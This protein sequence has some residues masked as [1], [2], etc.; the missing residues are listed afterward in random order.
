MARLPEYSYLV[1]REVRPFHFMIFAKRSIHGVLAGWLFLGAAV[2]T[3]AQG[4]DVA[5]VFPGAPPAADGS[6][7]VNLTPSGLPHG[8]R[9]VGESQWHASGEVVGGLTTS[10]RD[11]EFRPVRGYNAPPQEKVHIVSGVA[12]TL[13]TFDYYDASATDY[14]SLTLTLKPDGIATA[15]GPNRAQWR[16]LGEDDSS[17]RDSNKTEEDLV[18]GSYLVECKPVAGR[19]TP[20]TATVIIDPS[21]NRPLTL[22]YF[23]ADAPIGTPPAVL[24]YESVTSDTTKPYAYV[25]QIR[26]DTT[27]GS[28]FV[29][30]Q[31]VVA[32]AAHV[33]WDDA[34]LSSVQGLQWLFQRHRGVHEPESMIPRGFYMFANYSGERG[35]EDTPGT[36]SPA[37]QDLDVAALYFAE[38]PGRGGHSGYVVSNLAQNEFL[39]SHASK[40]LVGYPMDGIA[41]IFQG[42][43]HATP[44]LDLGFDAVLGKTFTTTGIH[45]MAGISGG[46]LCVQ[47]ED[48]NYYPAAICLAGGGQT[49]VRAID[50]EVEELFN[51]AN[52]GIVG[53]GATHIAV[54]PIEAGGKGAIRII[55]EPAAARDASA[56]WRLS[57]SLIARVSGHQISN[58][59]PGGYIASLAPLEGYQIPTTQNI[60]IAANTLT[61]VTYTY[62]TP[63]TPLESW[64]QLHFGTNATNS[65]DAAD[66][67]DPDHDGFNNLAEYT[68]DT[69]PTSTMDYLRSQNPTRGAGTFSLSTA[70]KAGRSYE[71][72]RSATLPAASWTSVA[73]QGP[74]ASDA[75][76]TLTDAA[77]PAGSAFYRI[78]VVVVP[79]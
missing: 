63:L 23:L 56:W 69:L 6:I 78:Q 10:N 7:S 22:T 55:I 68:A 17:W 21:R 27:V 71:L 32:T 61:T 4:P 8:W 18:P 76:V 54:T 66:S 52:S 33:L 64:R 28:G 42:R 72:Q 74:L 45:G 36:F 11:I 57:P 12:P 5:L 77:S 37:S 65:G 39:L 75:T 40:M 1:R 53:G 48:G 19:S 46:P 47:L 20:P 50:S 60:P 24:A 34:T 25:G 41:A 43:V 35:L 44:P 49:V 3:R 26:S 2:Q 73:T 51:S 16:F 13:H 79:P 58:L 67:A 70:G 59:N 62:Q 31:R 30:R 29:V 14:G 38:D 15:T 9:F